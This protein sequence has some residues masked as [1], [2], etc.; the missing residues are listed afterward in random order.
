LVIFAGKLTKRV[1]L[2]EPTETLTDGDLVVTYTTV[3]SRWAEPISQNAREF[4]TARE[5]WAD[6]THMFRIR[7]YE[8]LTSEWRLALGS[9]YFNIL[10]VEDVRMEHVEQIIVAKEALSG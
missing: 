1:E 8:D 9:R 5:V 4:T 2:Q 7:Y 6:A 3:V 10:S